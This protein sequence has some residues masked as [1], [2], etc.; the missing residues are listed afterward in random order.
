M[1]D[2]FERTSAHN[3]LAPFLITNLTRAFGAGPGLV[4]IGAV[5]LGVGMQPGP[6]VSAVWLYRL[7]TYWLPV[8][9]GW[10]WHKPGP[11]C[12]PAHSGRCSNTPTSTSTTLLNWLIC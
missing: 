11:A 6:A 4:V 10:L 3:H 1:A 7:A 9:P 8:L 2:G 12:R 5:Y